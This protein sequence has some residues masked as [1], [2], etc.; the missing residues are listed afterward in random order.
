MT[1]SQ[2]GQFR[3]AVAF[4]TAF[5]VQASGRNDVL[6]AIGLSGDDEAVYDALVHRTQAT[7]AEL[8]EDCHR[9]LASV[10]RAVQRL[11]DLGL[12]R[13]AVEVD[14]LAQSVTTSE[15]VSFVPALQGLGT[16]F[17]DDG[18]QAAFCGLTRGSGRAQLARAVLEGIAHRCVD[19]SEALGLGDI[20][21]R[22]DGGL[23]QS[24]LLLQMVADYG[25]RDVLRAA[26]VEATA[27]GAAFLAGLATGVFSGPEQCRGLIEA[28]RRFTPAIDAGARASAREEWAAVLERVRRGA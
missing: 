17:A 15:G 8:A 9:P 14:S 2:G 11:V 23:A 7:A 13:D 28:S 18:A 26:E 10:R 20:A 1:S 4:P 25:R 12:A 3:S 6:E 27:I 5:V 24:R 16:P 22:V 21:L 19:V